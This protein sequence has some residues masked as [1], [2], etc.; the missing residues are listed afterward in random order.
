MCAPR[1]LGGG[2]GVF[3]PERRYDGGRARRRNGLINYLPRV[4]IYVSRCGRP[5]AHQPVPGGISRRKSTRSDTL[6]RYLWFTICVRIVCYNSVLHLY[7]PDLVCNI[8]CVKTYFSC[9][10]K[11]KSGFS[12][13]TFFLDR[14]QKISGT[15]ESIA[16]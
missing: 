4:S 10:H 15:M 1:R 9:T 7:L 16:V 3:F 12:Q 5:P 6:H 11:S 8:L 13:G 2:R 14:L